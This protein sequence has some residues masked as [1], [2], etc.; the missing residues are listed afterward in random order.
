MSTRL[1][2]EWDPSKARTNADKHGLTFEQAMAVFDDPL[3][4]SVLDRASAEEERWIT[5]GLAAAAGIV[6]VV[7]THIELDSETAAIR[8]ISARRPT[9]N[10]RRQYEN[11]RQ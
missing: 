11:D 1:L 10:E 7:H 5:I 3:A 9:A 4:L 6:L 8:I 2:F